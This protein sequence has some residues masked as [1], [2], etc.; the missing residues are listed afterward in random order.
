VGMSS[1][2]VVYKIFSDEIKDHPCVLEALDVMNKSLQ[3]GSG[4]LSAEKGPCP[5]SVFELNFIVSNLLFC[6]RISFLGKA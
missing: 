4:P 5:D 6:C 3:A 2:I 1:I